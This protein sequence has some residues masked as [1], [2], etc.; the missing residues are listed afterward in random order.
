M[1]G[2]RR[3]AAILGTDVAGCSRLMRAD[4]VGTLESYRLD[5]PWPIS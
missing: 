2:I 1:A 4:E 5:C 3:L